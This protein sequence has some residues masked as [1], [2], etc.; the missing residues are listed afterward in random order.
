MLAVKIARNLPRLR[1][2]GAVLALAWATAW[3]RGAA[4][5]SVAAG[6]PDVNFAGRLEYEGHSA[7]SHVCLR[8]QGNVRSMLFVR[9][10]GE[11]VLESQIDL[12]KPYVLRFEYLRA[13]FASYLVCERPQD[14]LIVGLGGGGMVH[15]LQKFDPT[16]RIDAVEIDPLVVELADKYFGVRTSGNV[17]VVTADG[18]AFIAEGDKQ[19]DVIYMDAFLKPSAETDATGAPLELRTQEFYR[20]MQA[21]LKPGGAV[22]FNINPHEGMV[23]DV[24]GVVRAFRQAYEFPLPRGQGVVVVA[25][26]EGARRKKMELVQRGRGLEKRFGGTV[27]CGSKFR[28]ETQRRRGRNAEKIKRK[29]G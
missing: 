4:A 6:R 22:A 26:M 3:P 1:V 9:D 19:Y 18:L 27:R 8:R 25:T 15:F 24:R 13:L 5:Q 21:R 23:E 10:S 11:E 29:I 14:V 2:L 7:F 20:Q 12:R 16:V 28:A 17:N